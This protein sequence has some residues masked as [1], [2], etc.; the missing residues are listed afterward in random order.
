MGI[1]AKPKVINKIIWNRQPTEVKT[2]NMVSNQYFL[3]ALL[4]SFLGE[5]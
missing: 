3:W 5:Q 4:G 1:R 2:C